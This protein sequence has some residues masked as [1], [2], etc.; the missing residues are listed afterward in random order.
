MKSVEVTGAGRDAGILAV[1]IDGK[2][3][4]VTAAYD[5]DLVV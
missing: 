3:I 4:N 2:T 5:T 1:A